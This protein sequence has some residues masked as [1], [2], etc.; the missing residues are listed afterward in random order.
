MAKWSAS[1][2]ELK[3]KNTLNDECVTFMHHFT[4][5]IYYI[6]LNN[7]SINELIHWS[8]ILAAT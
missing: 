1:V 7:L 5:F 3:H 2:E 6:L 4:S 8:S